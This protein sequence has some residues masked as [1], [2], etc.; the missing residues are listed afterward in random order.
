MFLGYEY[1]FTFIF[2]MCTLVVGV[3]TSIKVTDL[4][5]RIK[6]TFF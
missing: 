4:I 2:L 6:V 1:I 3:S 5:L